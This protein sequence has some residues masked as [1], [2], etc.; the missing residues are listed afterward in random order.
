MAM[1]PEGG[2]PRVSVAQCV[3]GHLGTLLWHLLS[4]IFTESLSLLS[5]I[6]R[7]QIWVLAALACTKL[8][9]QKNVS[10]QR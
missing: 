9:V 7:L 8:P 10:Q 5:S 2:S 1:T 3:A 6:W 4:R